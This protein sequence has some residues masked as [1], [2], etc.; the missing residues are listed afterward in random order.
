MVI[1]STY[2][3]GII[4]EVAPG[5]ANWGRNT[6]IEWIRIRQLKYNMKLIIQ[7]ITRK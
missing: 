5:V 6:S 2:C 1:E 4:D 7:Y 3:Q